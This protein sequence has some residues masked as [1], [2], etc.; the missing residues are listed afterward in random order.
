SR[1]VELHRRV[2]EVLELG[3]RDNVVE[4]LRHLV[5]REAQKHA[6]DVDVLAAGHLRVKPHAH[7]DERRYAASGPYN[8]T[9]WLRDAGHEAEQGGLP[10]AVSTDHAD[11]L[12]SAHR[13]VDVAKGVDW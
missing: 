10:G 4:A 9:R 8:A 1:R 13:E 2:D 6:V 12:T 3:E 5:R 11:R 7:A